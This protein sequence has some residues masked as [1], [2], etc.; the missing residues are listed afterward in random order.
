MDC[1]FYPLFIIR[2]LVRFL[3][4]RFLRVHMSLRSSASE[5]PSAWVIAACTQVR[6]GAQQ[7]FLPRGVVATDLFACDDGKLSRS[8]H[9]GAAWQCREG[10]V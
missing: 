6:F 5:H 2:I 9:R 8:N 1:N 10:A 4:L 3:R 7:V